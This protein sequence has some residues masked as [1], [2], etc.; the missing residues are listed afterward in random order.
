MTR[1]VE[2]FLLR[3]SVIAVALWTA[4]VL[5]APNIVIFISDDMGWGD[6]GYHGS[7]INT[8]EI[9]RLASE[10]V[11]L[12]RFYV[13]SVCS[14]TRASLMTG[15]TSIQH[16]VASPFNPW[17]ERGL[18]VDEKLLPEYLREHGYA[19][20]AVGK[21][22][23]G[24]NEL[25][26]HPLNRGFDTYYGSLH[27]YAANHDTRT[28]FGR[29]D[30]QRD[31]ETVIEDGYDTHLIRDE[32]IRLIENRDADR[33]FFLY[34]TFTAPH[35]PLQAPEEAIAEYAHLEG[36]R[37]VY[38][39]MVS[40]MDAAVGRVVDAIAREGIAE[41]TFVMFFT[42][43][44]GVL[45]AGASNGPFRGAKASPFEGGIRVPAVT[46]WPGVLVGG[47]RFS[48]RVMVMDLLPTFMDMADLPLDPV[49]PLAG[50]SV[51][52]ALAEGVP[53]GPEPAV[54]SN[55]Q[56]GVMMHAYF[57]DEW[58][59]VRTQSA[60]GEIQDL[61]FEIY[62][63]P[64]EEHDVS[65]DFPEVAAR[66]AAEL[67]AMPKVESVTAGQRRPDL[68]APGAPSSIQ[69]DT[70]PAIGTPFAESGPIPYPTENY[71]TE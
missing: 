36:N 57:R 43:N 66:M 56:A 22:H 29:V 26:Y 16:G 4:P 27:G 46:Y 1:K 30:W 41:D 39:A 64:G 38:A 52:P 48:H 23:L 5:A 54:L 70:R 24:P 61:L 44:G 37:R 60:S 34:V 63:D 21:W 55:L 40:E 58:K 14:P 67:D 3:V 49:K 17:F 13:Q 2:S 28:A 18:P 69:P 19:T 62:S 33:P 65:A 59:L 71:A 8:P 51:W 20:H 6:V 32:A 11:I 10:G 42:D 47:T 50:H 9:D 12:E 68:E 45:N 35:T 53:M 15:R 25:Q 7:D 31:G